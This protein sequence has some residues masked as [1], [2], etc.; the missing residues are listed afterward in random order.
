METTPIS[1]D[2]PVCHTERVSSATPRGVLKPGDQTP[3]GATTGQGT[4]KRTQFCPKVSQRTFN[5]DD[6][7][8]TPLV[9]D[10]TAHK[11]V[12]NR[13]PEEENLLP[14]CKRARHCGLTTEIDAFTLK[15]IRGD[16]TRE[17]LKEICT[18]TPQRP[19]EKRV[20]TSSMN[21]VSSNVPL[22]SS[23]FDPHKS[24]ME[25]ESPLSKGEQSP[26][27]EFLTPQNPPA[28]A[29][30]NLKFSSPRERTGTIMEFLKEKG[31]VTPVSNE[32]SETG[33]TTSTV[34]TLTSVTRRIMSPEVQFT[35]G[36]VS[37]ANSE[38]SEEGSDTDHGSPDKM[39]HH[40]LEGDENDMRLFGACE[41]VKANHNSNDRSV[42]KTEKVDTSGSSG[43]NESPDNW[44]RQTSSVN[45][46]NPA[47]NCTPNT[48]ILNVSDE[49]MQTIGQ[50]GNSFSERRE[51]GVG[52]LPPSPAVAATP[53]TCHSV[54]RERS[55]T[56]E[57]E[58]T[59]NTSEDNNGGQTEDNNNVDG[60]VFVKF[61][62][63]HEMIDDSARLESSLPRPRC[64]TIPF[65]VE[66]DNGEKF[67]ESMC[68]SN[69]TRDS[70]MEI[71]S[72][73]VA[74]SPMDVTSKSRASSKGTP[75]LMEISQQWHH[76]SAPIMRTPY[77]TPKSCR[78][79]NRPHASPPKNRILGTPDYLA[80]EILL[81]H[82]HTPAVDWWSLGVCLYEFLTG[83]P[84]FNDDTPELVFSHIM[85]RELLWPEGDEALSEIAVEAVENI[86]NLHAE[87]RPGALEIKRLPFF[88]S[89]DWSFI[90]SHPPPFV[91]RPDDI[92][93]TTYF[94]ARNTM[95][96]LR[97][98]SFSH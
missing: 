25:Y 6:P 78:R 49:I 68:T 72:P 53:D 76:T 21:S 62:D 19:L 33:R 95:Q 4:K 52:L 31:Q 35:S 71:S 43:F 48:A 87:H 67:E 26:A 83:V 9:S 77:R 15:E 41:F 89:L 8:E 54:P 39:N 93:D 75:G 63:H 28:C 94:D 34:T 86:L 36:Y 22:A 1:R 90:H 10:A 55:M 20:L 46:K 65:E 37:G 27:Q 91:P 97:L 13:S 70:C 50:R 51:S 14:A 40:K 96:N 47:V 45:E 56:I 98:S 92:T 38:M 79:G 80:P 57:F 74:E 58:G 69:Q 81:G 44:P 7:P 12:R 29:P 17:P 11:N 23:P 88:S 30:L 73:V 5:I 64:L 61:A 59:E 18:D 2:S 42:Q 60:E 32:S 3:L 66:N 85:Q 84:P 24:P 82:E 16:T